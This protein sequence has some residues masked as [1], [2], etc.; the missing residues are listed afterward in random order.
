M[1]SESTLSSNTDTSQ[2]SRETEANSSISKSFESQIPISS[3]LKNT[4]IT[5]IVANLKDVIAENQQ[6]GKNQYIYKDNLFYLEQ[7]PS[8]SLEKYIRHIIKYTQLNISTL[9]IS[10]IYI[11]NFCE[12]FKYALTLNNIYRLVLISIYLSLKYNEDTIVNTKRYAA[13]AG[14]SPEDLQNLEM[15]MCL[16]LDFSFYVKS[17]YYQ[18]YF[19]YFSNFSK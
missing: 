17:E 18:Q 5:S 13:I 3:N 10:I 11:D 1:M 9:I 7:I 16:A 15:Q 14:V 8:I 6:N 2:L 19:T 12:K 4:I